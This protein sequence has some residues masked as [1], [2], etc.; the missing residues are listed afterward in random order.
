MVVNIFMCDQFIIMY[1]YVSNQQSKFILPAPEMQKWS[2]G[3]EKVDFYNSGSFLI[4]FLVRDYLTQL[5][6]YVVVLLKQL[7]GLMPVLLMLEFG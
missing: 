6:V 5:K 4:V 3:N 7:I 1:I 2:F